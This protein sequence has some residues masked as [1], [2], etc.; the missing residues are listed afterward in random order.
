MAGQTTLPF[1]L[2]SDGEH[3]FELRK[4]ITKPQTSNLLGIDFCRQYVSK[5]H[6][7]LPAIELKNTPNA[8][9]YGNLCS[10]KS[11]PSSKRYTLFEHLTRFILIPRPPE[12]EKTRRKTNRKTSHQ[13]PPLFLIDTKSNQD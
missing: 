3:Q 9:C 7:E 6:L 8:I 2:G 4:R 11:Y 13:E 10:T 1:T 5:L 12:F